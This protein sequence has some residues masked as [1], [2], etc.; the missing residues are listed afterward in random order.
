MPAETASWMTRFFEARDRFQT[1][2]GADLLPTTHRRS[3]REGRRNLDRV[4]TF[5]PRSGVV[6]IGPPGSPEAPVS[7]RIPPATR[8]ALTMLFYVRSQPL[9]TGDTITAPV[10]DG[11]RNLVVQIKVARRE[12]ITVQGRRV[13]AIRLEPTIVERV[14]RRD[15]IESVV[16]IGDDARKAVIAAD[17]AAGFGRL[18]LELIP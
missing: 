3:L 16:W 14:P 13:D 7:F 2:A 4:Y 11:G 10:N 6:R 9:A 18:R 12:S 15:P 8:D 5:D 1:D 17:I